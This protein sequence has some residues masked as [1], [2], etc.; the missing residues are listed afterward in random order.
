MARDCDSRGLARRSNGQNP[1]PLSM[2]IT[3]SDAER[4]FSIFEGYTTSNPPPRQCSS[5][6]LLIGLLTK[7]TCFIQ[8]IMLQKLSK[9]FY[10]LNRA[11]LSVVLAVSQCP[12]VCLS[13][14][15]YVCLSVRYTRVCGEMS[16]D[17]IKLFLDHVDPVILISSNH[18]ALP[19]SKG[20]PSARASN[21][22]WVGKFAIFCQCIAISCKVYKKG[23]GVHETL[24]GSNRPDSRNYQ[25]EIFF[26]SFIFLYC[27]V[28]QYLSFYI[29]N[30]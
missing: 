17:I 3:F 8:H 12:S 5:G 19:N 15:L 16:G 29:S 24:I 27:V 9:K 20:T 7:L 4:G 26:I 21:R 18:P 22:G 1:P 2:Y 10:F 25:M 11:T 13:V 23:T 14:C 28:E 30:L 6:Y